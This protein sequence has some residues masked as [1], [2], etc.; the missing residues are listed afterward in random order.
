M[1]SKLASCSINAWSVVGEVEVDIVLSSINASE[2]YEVK[3]AITKRA[4][5][6]G[7]LQLAVLEAIANGLVDV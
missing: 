3:T 1:I 6:V 5:V 7:S 4:S 2:T